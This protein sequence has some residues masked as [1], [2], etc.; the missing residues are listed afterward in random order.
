VFKY[1]DPRVFLLGGILVLYITDVIE[2]MKY[3]EETSPGMKSIPSHQNA[4]KTFPPHH[5][6]QSL[7]TNSTMSARRRCP[8]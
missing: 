3:N 6:A 2:V 1:Y 7:S 5:S 8:L 4:I